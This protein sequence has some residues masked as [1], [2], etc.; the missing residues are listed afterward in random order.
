MTVSRSR[1]FLTLVGAVSFA[2]ANWWTA[3]AYPSAQQTGT[4]ITGAVHEAR[5]TED[6]VLSGVRIEVAGGELDGRVFT[7][8]TDGTFSLS[9]VQTVGF[10]LEFKKEGYDSFRV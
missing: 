5:P 2:T 8:G 9:A 4:Q 1:S 6:R 10:S 7:T 3:S